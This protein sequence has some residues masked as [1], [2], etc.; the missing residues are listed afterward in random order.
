MIAYPQRAEYFLKLV[1]LRLVIVCLEHAKQ[2]TLAETAR[3]DK[4][5]VSWLLFKQ[6]YIHG[7]INIIKIILYYG[8]EVGYSVWQ[9]LN[10][11]HTRDIYRILDYVC[12]DTT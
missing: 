3:A 2:Q 8:L 10:L 12:K 9:L 4:H 6:R 5:K 7:F 1:F 11:I